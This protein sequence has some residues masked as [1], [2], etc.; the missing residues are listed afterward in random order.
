MVGIL[1]DKDRIFLNI[2]GVHDWGLEGAKLRGAWNGTKDIVAQTPEWICDQMKASGLR[3]RGGAGFATGLKWTFMP[4]Q[5]SERPHYLLVNA[6]GWRA[7][8]RGARRHG[9][10]AGQKLSLGCQNR[11]SRPRL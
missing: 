3:G 7:S 2:Y 4:K 10:A 5:E 8:Y 11:Q 9:P 1:A 6:D